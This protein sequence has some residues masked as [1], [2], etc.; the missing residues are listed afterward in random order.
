MQY[1]VVLQAFLLALHGSEVLAAPF[2]APASGLDLAERDVPNQSAMEVVRRAMDLV[3][4]SSSLTRRGFTC[5]TCGKS[6][7]SSSAY[8]SHSCHSRKP[9]SVEEVA[10]LAERDFEEE[11]SSLTRR[12]FTCPTCGK[13]FS[14][15]SA[16]SSHSCHSR[17]P[18]SVDAAELA[19]R[20][21]AEPSAEL[22]RRGF[23]CPTCGKSF[24]TSSAYSSHSCHSRKPR[25]LVEGVADLAERDFEHESSSLTRR[26]FTCPTCGKSFSSSSAYSSHSCHSRKPRSVDAAELAERDLAEPSAELTRRG[27]TCP[28]CGKSFSSSSAYSSHSCHSRKPRDLVEGVADLAERDFEQESSSLTRR[29]FTCP[30]CG[31]SFSSSSAYSSHSCHSRKP[32]S[33]E[34]SGEL[35]ERDLPESSAKLTRRG[36][37]CPTCGKS[38]SSSS[39]YG[40]HSCH[41]RKPR[42]VDELD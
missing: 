41:S 38:F 9:R 6:F 22:T 35:A 4:E 16:Y 39:A 11:S 18:R 21:L 28:T 1:L 20:D 30:T 10:D 8:S 37:T 7:S 3:D 26:G 12:G 32:R 24:S 33:L 25:D 5:P 40:S 42:S 15:S 29:G 19:E 14:S 31:K 23:T 13:S 34:F 17:K 36:F 27:F 2:G